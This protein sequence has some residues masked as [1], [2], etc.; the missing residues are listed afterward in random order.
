[1]AP[2]AAPGAGSV[3]TREYHAAERS[4]TRFTAAAAPVGSASSD[5]QPTIVGVGVSA[6]DITM[7]PKGD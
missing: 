1:M 5:G 4:A 7:T 3:E 2:T 6:R